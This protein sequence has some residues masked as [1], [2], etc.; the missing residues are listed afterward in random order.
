MEHHLPYD[1]TTVDSSALCS[2][3][4]DRLSVLEA[5]GSPETANFPQCTDITIADDD[6]AALE[7]IGSMLAGCQIAWTRTTLCRL[8]RICAAA[9]PS[10][11]GWDPQRGCGV[12]IRCQELKWKRD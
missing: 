5:A 11:T 8:G 10:S 7:E 2:V 4:T 1:S 3:V 6:V 9:R 12:T